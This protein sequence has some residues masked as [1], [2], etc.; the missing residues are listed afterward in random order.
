MENRHL[1]NFVPDVWGDTFLA[2]PPQLDL[3]DITRSEYQELKEQN[4]DDLYTTAVRFR[5]LREHGFHVDSQTFNKFK[6]EEGDFKK[7]LISDVKGMLQLYEAAH[8]QERDKRTHQVVERLMDDV[9]SH[10]FEQERGHVSSAV[11]CYMNQYGTSMQVAYEEL[12][13]QLLASGFIYC[14][15]LCFLILAVAWLSQYAGEF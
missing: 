14:T 4:D 9:V 12:F 8:F 10:K 15:W 6:D 11:E 5:L 2:P 7:S 3:D 13:K 1:A